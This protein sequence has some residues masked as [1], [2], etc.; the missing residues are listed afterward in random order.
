MCRS[1]PDGGVCKPPGIIIDVDDELVHD[2]PIRPSGDS[3][4]SLQTGVDQKPWHEALV[5]SAYIAD[6][7]P[8]IFRACPNSN[9]LVYRCHEQT[10]NLPDAIRKPSS[11]G[12]IVLRAGRAGTAEVSC[13][14]HSIIGSN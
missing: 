13:R 2:H 12:G 10:S 9:F 6:S 5:D 14:Y 7:C 3:R 11:F 4:V 1:T 8:H